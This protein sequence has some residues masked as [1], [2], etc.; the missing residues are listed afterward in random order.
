[1]TDKYHFNFIG[2]FLNT[3]I[4]KGVSP[5]PDKLKEFDY[6]ILFPPYNLSFYKNNHVQLK[7]LKYYP[8]TKTLVV[9]VIR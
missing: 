4:P 7:S 8:T 3:A 1:M 9:K 5:N 2:E 6:L